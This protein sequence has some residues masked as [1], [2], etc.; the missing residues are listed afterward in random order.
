MVFLHKF[1]HTQTHPTKSKLDWNFKVI[2]YFTEVHLKTFNNELS[3]QK[4]GLCLFWK[5]TLSIPSFDSESLSLTSF[6]YKIRAR[7]S[8]GYYF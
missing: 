2:N 4:T 7:I 1:S 6:N 5:Q 8:P 3:G